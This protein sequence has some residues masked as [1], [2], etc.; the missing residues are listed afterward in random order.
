V[1]GSSVSNNSVILTAEGAN[2]SGV[3]ISGI[4]ELTGG[5]L[6]QP[7]MIRVVQVIIPASKLRSRK[8][9]YGIDFTENIPC[10]LKITE[11]PA[12]VALPPTPPTTVAGVANVSFRSFDPVTKAPA[13]GIS[14]TENQGSRSRILLLKVQSAGSPTASPAK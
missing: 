2:F 13:M 7:K 9:D 11:S 12:G 14:I 6:N 8:T 4:Q 10:S 1:N 3:T 5:G